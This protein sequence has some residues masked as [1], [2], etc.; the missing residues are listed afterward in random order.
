MY[1]I[2]ID[3]IMINPNGL[4]PGPL[5]KKTGTR[6]G[7]LRGS[8]FSDGS[9]LIRLCVEKKMCKES[10]PWTY[11]GGLY[12]LVLPTTFALILGTLPLL[13]AYF[14]LL[15]S[16][17][18]LTQR[19]LRKRTGHGTHRNPST[20]SVLEMYF[21]PSTKFFINLVMEPLLL[22]GCVGIFSQFL[23]FLCPETT[24]S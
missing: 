14:L 7:G 12:R 17:L 1:S 24:S 19:S 6:R 3:L 13:L 2:G 23:L 4:Y 10:P 9:P 16:L 22:F 20:Q 11:F 18:S 5:I 21:I 8:E 15:V